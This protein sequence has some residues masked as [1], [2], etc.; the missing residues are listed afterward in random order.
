[1]VKVKRQAVIGPKLAVGLDQ[2]TLSVCVCVL[3]ECLNDEI[4]S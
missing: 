1:M 2:L 3:A 4:F